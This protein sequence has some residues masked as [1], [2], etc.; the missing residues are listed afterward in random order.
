VSEAKAGMRSGGEILVSA[1]RVHGVDTVFG[2]PGESS[3]PFFDALLQPDAGVRFVQC[4]HEANA[5][6]MAEADAKLRGVP[7]ACI[8]SRGPGAMHAA[9]GLHTARQDSTPMLLIIGQVPTTERG[10]EGFQEV[11]YG[12]MFADMTKWVGEVDTPEKLPEYVSRALHIATHGRPGPVVL[13][14][15]EDVLE[16]TSTIADFPAFKPA[17]ASPSHADMAKVGELLKEAE[18]PLVIVGGSGWTVEA[19]RQVTRFCVENNLPVAAGFRS[20]DIVDNRLDQYVGDLSL[21]GNP[22]LVE[23]VM[24]ADLLLVIGDRL[25]EITTKAYTALNVPV[26]NQTLIHVF[27]G[28]EDLGSVYNPHLPILSNVTRFAEALGDLARLDSSAWSNWT[29]ECRAVYEAFQET[30]VKAVGLNI[31]NIIKHLSAALP[32]D[33][34]VTNGAGNYNIWLH[35]FFRYKMFPSQIA[36]KSGSMGYGLPAAIASKLRSPER[37]VVALAGDGCFMMASPDFATAVQ[38]NLGI[39]V[40]II[41]NAT[42]GSIRMHQERHYPGRPSG[43]A[44]RNPDFAMLAK[45]YGVFG[46]VVESEEQFPAALEEALSSGGP[47]IIEVRVSE[48]QLT[49]DFMI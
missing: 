21:G 18:R 1:L 45:T 43:T 38:N 14:V 2:V 32:E 6:H 19:S 31:A 47:A 41:N 26:P 13:C 46:T 40:I 7:G 3:L 27:P 11:D 4:R 24:A 33:A 9:I 39:V 28:P 48:R 5:S 37:T 17:P 42:Y 22:A 30:P 29:R 10:R 20:Q 34:I 35:R 16:A 15:P 12:R 25:S 36:P 8:V 44:L 23:R 49:P